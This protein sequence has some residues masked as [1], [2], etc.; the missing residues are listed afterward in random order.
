MKIVEVKILINR[1]CPYAQQGSRQIWYEAVMNGLINVSSPTTSDI[2]EYKD[3]S[4]NW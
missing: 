1:A 3:G 2:K 4:N